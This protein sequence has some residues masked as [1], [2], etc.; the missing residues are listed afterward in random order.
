M[1]TGAQLIAEE[2]WHQQDSYTDGHDDEHTAAELAV[3]AAILAT[4]GTDAFVMGSNE[5][6]D[7]WGLVGKYYDNRVRQLTIAGALIA[8]EIDRLQRA[9]EKP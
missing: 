6:T 7:P 4:F 9:E 8:A 2:R 3:N 5:G 1:K